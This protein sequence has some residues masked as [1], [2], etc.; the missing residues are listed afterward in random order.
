MKWI[1]LLWK[2][3]LKQAIERPEIAYK[4]IQKLEKYKEELDKSDDNTI[5]YTDP[6]ARKSPNK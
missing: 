4:Q 3:I 5:N 6:E 2:K 1:K